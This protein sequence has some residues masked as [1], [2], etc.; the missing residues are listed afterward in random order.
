MA[1]ARRTGLEGREFEY[2]QSFSPMKSPLNIYLFH[3]WSFINVK[4]MQC[5]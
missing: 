2:Q 4:L 5:R 3:Q 1:R